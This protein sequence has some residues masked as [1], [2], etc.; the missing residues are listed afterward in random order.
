MTMP[1]AKVSSAQQLV[2]LLV[3]VPVRAMDAS[4]LKRQPVF[5]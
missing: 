5:L 2:P 1:R 3:R 4:Q